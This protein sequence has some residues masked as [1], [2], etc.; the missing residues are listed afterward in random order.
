MKNEIRDIINTLFNDDTY[1]NVIRIKG[2]YYCENSWYEVNACKNEI[3]ISK[4]ARGQNVIIVIGIN[5]NEEK[6]EFVV[7]IELSFE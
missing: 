6:N 2:F 7:L 3:T 1:G 5:L 4:I